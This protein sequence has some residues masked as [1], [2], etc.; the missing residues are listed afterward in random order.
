[1]DGEERGT[2]ENEEKD[3]KSKE[4]DGAG[5][6]VFNCSLLISVL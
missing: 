1:M 3:G 6:K 5:L 2:A 4:K